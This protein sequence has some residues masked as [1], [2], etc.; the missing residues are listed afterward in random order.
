MDTRLRLRSLTL[1]LL[2]AS[3]GGR[4]QVGTT[5]VA[6]A[7]PVA[8]PAASSP[9]QER[10]LRFHGPYHC[11][12]ANGARP[13]LIERLDEDMGRGAGGLRYLGL[14]NAREAIPRLRE[15]TGATV[16][17][18]VR[19]RAV[20]ALVEIGD[21]EWKDRLVD[22]LRGLE[23][24]RFAASW[25]TVADAL[26]TLDAGAALS[27]ARGWMEQHPSVEG[28]RDSRRA[29]WVVQVIRDHG[30]A[31]MIPRLA[32]WGSQLEV[33]GGEAGLLTAHVIAARMALGE[34]PFRDDYVIAL[35]QLDSA[36]QFRPE[37][38]LTGMG[39]D[40]SEIEALWHLARY[41]GD[42]AIA[43]YDAIDRLAPALTDRQRSDLARRLRE[44]ADR[45]EGGI[46]NRVGGEILARYHASMTRLGHEPSEARLVQ[47][48]ARADGS[49]VS[50]VAARQALALDLPGAVDTALGALAQA[51]L[52][53]VP[54]AADHAAPL[55][56]DLAARL[57]AADGRWALGLLFPSQDVGDRALH[58]LSRLRPA[59]ACAVVTDAVPGSSDHFVRDALLA[60]TTM[61]S[62]CRPQLEVLAARPDLS[63]SAQIATRDVLALMR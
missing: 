20:V 42:T 48:S 32:A 63:R 40:A 11:L 22:V 46:D 45:L 4:A 50:L 36:R 26:L 37:V 2:L 5:T 10:C 31:S 24:S 7:A 9:E 3:C 41:G 18:R 62:A 53:S 57:G 16:D 39:R 14:L 23:D 1:A 19:V 6:A 35:A 55:V 29:V 27:Y 13:L 17:E 21:L 52:R 59:T 61:E 49:I 43:A 44:Y 47:L 54:G 34:R 56:D 8:G 60:L 28:L 12:G 51:R 30:D 38:V 25:G 58:H 15:L 33:R